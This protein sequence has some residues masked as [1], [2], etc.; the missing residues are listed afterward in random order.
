M[1]R[2]YVNSDVHEESQIKHNEPVGGRATATAHAY[3]A[4][5]DAPSALSAGDEA[6][7]NG[8]IMFAIGTKEQV[9]TATTTARTTTTCR[10]C[11]R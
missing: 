10:P 3:G 11:I 1:S 5:D 9:T 4:S 6:L 8:P 7:M 2:V